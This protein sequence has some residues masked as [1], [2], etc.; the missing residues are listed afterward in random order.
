MREEDIDKIIARNISSYLAESGKDQQDFADYMNVSQ[1]TI[2]YWCKGNKLPRMNKIDQICSYFNI[3]RSDL[4]NDRRAVNICSDSAGAYDP[5]MKEL[6]D[7]LNTDKTAQDIL[8][9]SRKLSKEDKSLIYKLMV[10]M[11]SGRHRKEKR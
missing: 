8:N 3:S 6:A 7:Y 1:A 10:S 5:V 9:E 11:N 4:F 2:S